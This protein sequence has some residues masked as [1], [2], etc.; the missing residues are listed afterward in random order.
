MPA[1]VSSHPV[2][3]PVIYRHEGKARKAQVTGHDPATGEVNGLAVYVGDGHPDPAKE[4]MVIDFGVPDPKHAEVPQH[5]I[6]D[7]YFHKAP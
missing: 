4:K 6:T 3:T 1:T 5:E 7:G 2:G